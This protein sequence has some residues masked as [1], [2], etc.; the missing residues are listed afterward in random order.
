MPMPKPLQHIDLGLAGAP[1][2]RNFLRYIDLELSRG[3]MRAGTIFPKIHQNN[4]SQHHQW[5][6]V[7]YHY[8][9]SSLPICTPLVGGPMCLP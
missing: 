4:R 9:Y 6:L 3:K 1:P 5:T 8:C 7:H 2:R